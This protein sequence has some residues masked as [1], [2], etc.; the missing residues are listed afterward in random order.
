M[1]FICRKPN[2]N[3][4]RP[5]SLSHA[6]IV[7]S[8]SGRF[9][10]ELVL[11]KGNKLYRIHSD[12]YWIHKKDPFCLETLIQTFKEPVTFHAYI[13]VGGFGQVRIGQGK[14]KCIA[15]NCIGYI[16][17]RIGYIKYSKAEKTWFP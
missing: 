7:V 10:I 16:W 3:L 9:Q 15:A 14:L 12:T 8:G 5:R 13:V 1:T 4:Y 17:I 11:S 6:Y 2:L